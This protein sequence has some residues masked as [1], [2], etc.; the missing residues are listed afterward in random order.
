[1]NALEAL[2]LQRAREGRNLIRKHDPLKVVFVGDF[3]GVFHYNTQIAIGLKGEPPF[4]FNIHG[5]E[6][7]TTIDHCRALGFGLYKE[8]LCV[9]RVRNPKTHRMNKVVW[10]VY[11]VHGKPLG[12]VK[13]LELKYRYNDWY[14]PDGERLGVD[15]EAFELFSKSYTFTD[16][17]R[18][19]GKS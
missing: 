15:T 5:W 12:E 10:D 7:R 11:C 13:G 6:T 8:K 3:Y 4:A 2:V 18:S 19:I 14:S 9:G 17:L 1:M 16:F